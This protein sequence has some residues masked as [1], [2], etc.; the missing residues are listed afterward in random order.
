METIERP[1]ADIAF[2][3]KFPKARER[4]P[5]NRA[6]FDPAV[7]TLAGDA[8]KSERGIVVVSKRKAKDL[9][10]DVLKDEIARGNGT[11]PPWCERIPPDTPC[12]TTG[13]WR[14]AYE[15]RSLA[16]NKEAS[17]RAF[18]RAAND[19]IEKRM[20]VAKHELWVW[21]TR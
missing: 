18:Y 2:N 9:A 20:Q 15:L 10:L 3:L 6:D 16:E 8:W 11:I 13:M 7:I 19:L 1:E 12:I 21:P 14:K 17:A 5:D 4:T